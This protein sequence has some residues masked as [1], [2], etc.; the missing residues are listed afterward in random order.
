MPILYKGKGGE[1]KMIPVKFN[2]ISELR[3]ILIDN[4]ELL[5]TDGEPAVEV[6]GREIPTPGAVGML[7]M[8]LVNSEGLPM[9]VK[10]ALKDSSGSEVIADSLNNASALAELSAEE[11]DEELDGTLEKALESFSS[12]LNDYFAVKQRWEACDSYLR[13]GELRIIIAVDD[14]SEELLRVVDFINENA[15]FDLRLV[16][17][18]KYTV[19]DDEDVLIPELLAYGGDNVFDY[20]K[21]RFL[22]AL[23]AFSIVAQKGIKIAGDDPDIRVVSPKGWGEKACY[24]FRDCGGDKISVGIFIDSQNAELKELINSFKDDLAS[25]VNWGTLKWSPDSGKLEIY[26]EKNTS[27]MGIAKA[28]KT[29]IDRTKDKITA[30]L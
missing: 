24:T 23:E 5:L 13:D 30:V 20:P 17:V 19:K 25:A 12:N 26:F 6:V 22:A 4:P 18:K 27:S 29:I 1:M 14:A 2:D 9:A 16:T 8:L 21:I 10:V 3:G 28:M 15:Y 7:D 11:L